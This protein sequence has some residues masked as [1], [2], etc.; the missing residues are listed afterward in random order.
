MTS[1]NSTGE[2]D[3]APNAPPG[4]TRRWVRIA[5]AISLAVNLGI[6]GIV[7]GALFRAGGPM[8]DGMMARDLGFG[9]FTEALSKEDRS[10]LRKAFLA[11][12]PDM[13]DDRRAMRMD[14]AAL[15]ERLRAVPFDPEG[16]RKAFERQN[17]RNYERLEL[18]Q[19]LIFEL[20]VGMTDD[21]R[22][23]FA[24]RLEQSLA[25]GPKQR[26]GATKP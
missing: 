5:L 6:A 3:P 11:K 16:L 17:T 14:F 25:K 21:A 2:T 7:V 26:D 20:V 1:S 12:V 24:G 18:G 9:A 4:Q 15:L 23:A 22:Q 10:A 8:H 13:R 19:K